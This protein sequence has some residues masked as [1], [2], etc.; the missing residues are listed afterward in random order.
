MIPNRETKGT[1][2]RKTNNLLNTFSIASESFK[3]RDDFLVIYKLAFKQ[4]DNLKLNF[5]KKKVSK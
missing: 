4:D 1:N 2:S 5:F 3:K